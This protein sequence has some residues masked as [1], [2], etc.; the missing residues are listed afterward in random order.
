M[1]RQKDQQMEK[2]QQVQKSWTSLDFLKLVRRNAHTP[3]AKKSVKT[4]ATPAIIPWANLRRLQS[5]SILISL[6]TRVANVKAVT[7]RHTIAKRK[8]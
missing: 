4:C 5:A 3:I 8:E 2:K 6:I 7:S 1:I